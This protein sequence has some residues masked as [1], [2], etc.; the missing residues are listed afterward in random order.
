[1]VS[2][3]VD[4]LL[5][6]G[7]TNNNTGTKIISSNIDEQLNK[8]KTDNCEELEDTIGV[9]QYDLVI[10]SGDLNYR[11]NM[12]IEDCKKIIEAKDYESL[13]VTLG[14]GKGKNWWC[15]LFPPLCLMETD[16]NVEYKFYVKE[17]IDKYF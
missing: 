10:F 16:E 5:I 12:E 2:P 14:K 7:E 13:L 4:Y 8:I 15:V 11:I 1:M 17:I 6:R 9:N 3:K